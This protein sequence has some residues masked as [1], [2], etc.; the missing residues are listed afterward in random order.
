MF[1]NLARLEPR[2]AYVMVK[3]AMEHPEL[4]RTIDNPMGK[5]V[6]F[7]HGEGYATLGELEAVLKQRAQVIAHSIDEYVTIRHNEQYMSQAEKKNSV[8]DEMPENLEFLERS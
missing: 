2:K 8:V 1:H 6:K 4:I 5:S 3:G 7:L